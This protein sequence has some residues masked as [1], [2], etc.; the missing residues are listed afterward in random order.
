MFRA[1]TPEGFEDVTQQLHIRLQV[2]IVIIFQILHPK[3]FPN[4]PSMVI[5]T[6]IN[7]RQVK[8]AIEC[9]TWG[10]VVRTVYHITNSK[11]IKDHVDPQIPMA[12]AC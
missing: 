8:F 3:L 1:G 9:F 10:K 2:E 5:V 7:F 11:V 4:S 12:I 6:L